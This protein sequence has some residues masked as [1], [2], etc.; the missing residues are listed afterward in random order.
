M[1]FSVD[2][3]PWLVKALEMIMRAFLWSVIEVV[4]GGKC[5]VAWCRVQR[6]LHVGLSLRLH[7]LWLQHTDRPNEVVQ[8][9]TNEG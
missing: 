4:Q 7:Y 2:F 6:P 1:S 8:R 9:I 5:S 3:P